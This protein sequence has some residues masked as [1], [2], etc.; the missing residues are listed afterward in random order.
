MFLDVLRDV[1]VQLFMVNRWHV[2]RELRDIVDIE[3]KGLTANLFIALAALATS[4]STFTSSQVASG[5]TSIDS[6]DGFQDVGV[7]GP[8]ARQMLR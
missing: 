7:S 2:E 4:S 5:T 8:R 3:I 6:R 1:V